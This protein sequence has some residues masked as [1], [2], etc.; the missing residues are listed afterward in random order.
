MSKV[1]RRYLPS[2]PDWGN[3]E[4]RRDPD[5][6]SWMIIY[7]DVMTLMLSVFVVLLAYSTYSPE[8]F[9]ELTRTLSET[10]VVQGEVDAVIE[11][12]LQRQ[13]TEA[14]IE[15]PAQVETEQ[16]REQYRQALL[17][18]GLEDSVEITVTSNRIDLQIRERILF[19]L[20]RADLTEGGQDLLGQLVPLLN[21]SEDNISVEGHTD[22]IPISNERFPSNWELSAQRAT[23][24]LRHLIT[25][26]V[27]SERLRA[28]GYADT[29]PVADNATE[30]G[31]ARNRRVSLVLHMDN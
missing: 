18:R 5:A 6:S 12:E 21:D 28:I 20:G 31:R 8:K 22:T 4:D 3:E 23:Q 14:A 10:V 19:Q 13:Q 15:E 26:G 9:D 1:E 7:L 16:L 30:D 29:H 24:V 17:D 25:Q 11:P 2:P 27:S